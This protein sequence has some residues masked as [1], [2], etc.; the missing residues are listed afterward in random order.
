MTLALRRKVVKQL[1]A[2]GS[3]EAALAHLLAVL[4]QRPDDLAAHVQVGDLFLAACPGR[5]V[6]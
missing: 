1:V 5:F 4:D 6:H 2:D 3:D